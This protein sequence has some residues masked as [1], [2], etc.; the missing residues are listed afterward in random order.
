MEAA[1][2]QHAHGKESGRGL[3]LWNSQL[4]WCFY[5][6]QHCWARAC[7]ACCMS[8]LASGLSNWIRIVGKPYSGQ[9]NEANERDVSARFF[10]TVGARLLRGRFFTEQ[11]DSSKPQ[12]VVINEAL[13]RKYFPN[14]DPIGKQLGNINLTPSSIK[15]IIGIVYDIREGSLDS[16]IWP[17]EYHPL[18]QDWSD[19]YALFARTAQNPGAALAEIERAVRSVHSDLGVRN[20]N[21]MERAIENSPAAALHRSCAWLIGGFAAC[22][23]ILGVVGLYGVIAYSVSQRTREIGVRMALGA[24]HRAVYTMIVREAG[25]LTALGIL[26]GAAAA[27]LCAGIAK[28]L[29]FH[30]SSWDPESVVSVALILGT[31]ALVAGFIPARRAASVS[32]LDALRAE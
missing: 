4:L 19:Y 20:V 22:A 11:E 25:H 9:H 6:A 2:P 5:S 15:T 12:V 27:I 14:E 29:L 31:S 24:Q 17:A 21:T 7:I 23:L 3:L 1:D 32:A 10:E 13:A 16:E 28:T 30:V 18:N 26:T 8:T